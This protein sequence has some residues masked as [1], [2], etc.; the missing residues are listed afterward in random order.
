MD[1]SWFCISSYSSLFPGIVICL[2]FSSVVSHLHSCYPGFH[3][4]FISCFI[5]KVHFPCVLSGLS[6]PALWVYIPCVTS[7]LLSALPSCLTPVCNYLLTLCVCGSACL[8][9][10]WLFCF[11][12]PCFWCNS[13]VFWYLLFF[14][15]FRLLVKKV[16]FCT[17]E[18]WLLVLKRFLV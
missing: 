13:N 12:V 5:W 4:I 6:F 16:G 8:L 7:V 3:C 1:F 11:V 10:V 2:L 18:L 15:I 17:I 9:F 14:L